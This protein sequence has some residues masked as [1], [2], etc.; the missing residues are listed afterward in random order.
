MNDLLLHKFYAATISVGVDGSMLISSSRERMLAWGMVFCFVAAFSIMS[1]LIARRGFVRNVSLGLLV[2]SIVLPLLMMP[3]LGDEYIRVSRE[4]ITID[5]GR[6]FMPS[7]TVVSLDNLQELRRDKHDYL[8]SNLIGDDYMTWKFERVDGKVQELVLNDF[9][10][11]HSMVVAH[12]IRD[13]GLPVKW[14]YKKKR[15][16][17]ESTISL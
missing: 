17:A 9:F 7:K 5:T 2:S 4:Q 11:A 14:L 10:S 3:S 16:E 1:M 8:V 15:P 12:Y 6:W 13:R